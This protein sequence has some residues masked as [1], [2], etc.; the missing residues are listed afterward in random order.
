MSHIT[1]LL[2][3]VIERRIVKKIENEVSRL[4]SGF[5]SGNNTR[6]GIFNLRTVCE[7]V[8]DLGKDVH[9]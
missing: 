6:I 1:K 8:I 2:L 5:R 4:Q 3:K 9:M 7:Q